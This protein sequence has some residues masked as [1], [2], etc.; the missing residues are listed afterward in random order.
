V[1]AVDKEAIRKV[2]T[3]M[4]IKYLGGSSDKNVHASCLLA[5]WR[6]KSLYDRHPSLSIS[7]DSWGNSLV[8]CHGCGYTGTLLMMVKTVNELNGGKFDRFVAMVEEA[9]KLKPAAKIEQ[10]LNRIK[11]EREKVRVYVD[12]ELQ[13]FAGKVP[14]YILDE[15]HL[16]LETCKA[17][18]IGYDEGAKRA[19]FPVRD[20][21]HNLVGMYGRSVYKNAADKH[22]HYWNWPKSRYLYGEHKISPEP[23]VIV[24][25]EGCI[26]AVWL[27]QNGVRPP[28]YNITATFG[29][30]PSTEQAEKISR[31][32]QRVIAF[33]DG[34][35]A[36]RAAVGKLCEVLRGKMGFGVGMSVAKCPSDK[37]PDQLSRHEIFEVLKNAE[38]VPLDRLSASLSR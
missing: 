9:E 10:N 8:N 7:I 3:A 30:L 27:W 16:T 26:D 32:Q 34:D 28:K 11:K 5:P 15:R 24:I 25:V 1:S 14:R 38:S 12:K 2:F 31:L 20:G 18:E 22:Y 29:S 17:W 37:D 13:P 19:V 6:H 23:R 35:A 4:G 21:E 36:G 33:F